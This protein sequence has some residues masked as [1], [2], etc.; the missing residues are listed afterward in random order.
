LAISDDEVDLHGDVATSF[1]SAYIM[2][3]LPD[4]LYDDNEFLNDPATIESVVTVESLNMTW[5][6]THSIG[7][8][9]RALIPFLRQDV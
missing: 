3:A 4:P 8:L 2:N 9:Y 5:L 6:K 1:S 7:D